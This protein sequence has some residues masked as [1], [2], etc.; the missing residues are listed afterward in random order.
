MHPS[1]VTRYTARSDNIQ[2]IRH[3]SVKS[4][5]RQEPI[6]PKI[7]LTFHAKFHISHSTYH[8]SKIVH[9]HLS[10][11]ISQITFHILNFPFTLIIYIY[12]FIS[13][14]MMWEVGNVKWDSHF[15]FLRCQ[16]WFVKRTWNVN[17]SFGKTGSWTTLSSC[18]ITE[19]TVVGS[20]Y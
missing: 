11:H 4:N 2:G 12:C 1:P 14:I 15:T 6:F 10:L 18:P 5:W 16:M 9:E 13:C 7:Q 19:Q 3:D 17:K 20:F 8:S